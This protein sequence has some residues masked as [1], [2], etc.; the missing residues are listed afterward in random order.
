MLICRHDLSLCVRVLIG[1]ALIRNK[2]SHPI[3]RH[4]LQG[5][6][7]FRVAEEGN[8]IPRRGARFALH[9]A[10]LIIRWEDYPVDCAS[11]QPVGPIREQVSNIDQNRGADIVF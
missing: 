2:V 3:T 10:H 1:I 7:S 6:S 4:R 9:S 5:N 11:K 8:R